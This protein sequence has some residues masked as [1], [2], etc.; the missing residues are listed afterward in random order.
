M[1]TSNNPSEVNTIYIYIWIKKHTNLSKPQIFLFFSEALSMCFFIHTYLKSHI[2][3][4]HFFIYIYIYIY[5][6]IYMFF[7][8]YKFVVLSANMSKFLEDL[9]LF[10]SFLRVDW[11]L[12][13]TDLNSTDHTIIKSIFER[14]KLFIL[15]WRNVWLKIKTCW[16]IGVA[17]VWFLEKIC[18]PS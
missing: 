15:S 10:K 13:L 2:W 11:K 6:Y 14:G 9:I 5:V 1:A 3:S 8:S 4:W 7:F 17:L 18:F 12:F 16:A